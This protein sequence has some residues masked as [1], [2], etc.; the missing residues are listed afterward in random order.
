MIGLTRDHAALCD[1]A[2]L[3]TVK[4]KSEIPAFFR[5]S[6]GIWCVPGLPEAKVGMR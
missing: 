3:N 4:F 1:D 2:K 5:L 6:R